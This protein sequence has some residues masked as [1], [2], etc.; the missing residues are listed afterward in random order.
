VRGSRQQQQRQQQ[1]AAAIRQQVAAGQPLQQ[2]G[3]LRMSG[4]EVQEGRAQLPLLQTVCPAP[5]GPGHGLL[6][7]A[8]SSKA[9]QPARHA[10]SLM[11]GAAA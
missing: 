10:P 11:L 3:V 5:L 7:P 4:G 1:Q 9:G 8:S 6:P 2:Q